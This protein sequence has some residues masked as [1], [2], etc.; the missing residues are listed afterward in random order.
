[1]RPLSPGAR[2]FVSWGT[3]PDHRIH[4]TRATVD[5]HRPRGRSAGGRRPRTLAGATMS[6]HRQGYAPLTDASSL[7]DEI[8]VEQHHVDR[9]YA[10][11]DELRRAAA[12]AEAASYRISDVGT[13]GALVERDAMVFH[14]ARRR[15]ALDAEHEGLVFGRLDLRDGEVYHVGRLGV[16][17]EDGE[18][19]VIDWRAPAAAAFYRATAAD[20]QGVVRRRVISSTGE[21]VTGIS[22]DLLDPA[23]APPG[24]RVVGDGALLAGLSRAT[25]R[26][27]RDIVAT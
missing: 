19:L 6:P 1:A 22:D 21:K 8:A 10:R 18:P 13:Y 15:Y 2:P 4:A 23:A 12:A 14:Q 16:R 24:M 3:V 9:V 17:D 26:G 11:V 7:R 27:M 25:G 5:R 20:P